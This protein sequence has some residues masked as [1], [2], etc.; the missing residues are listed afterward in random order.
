M[1]DKVRNSSRQTAVTTCPG[2]DPEIV[3]SL[4][5]SVAA[6]AWTLSLHRHDDADTVLLDSGG[7]ALSP[8]LGARLIAHATALDAATIA[9]TFDRQPQ[10]D[11]IDNGF[12][13]GGAAYANSVAR[14]T[15]VFAFAT[16]EL[17]SSVDRSVKSGLRAARR[18]VAPYFRLWQAGMASAARSDSLEA[19]LNTVDLGIILVD[20]EGRLVFVNELASDLLERSTVL[21]RR[22][23]VLAAMTLAETIELQSSIALA[24]A[25][26]ADETV[27]RVLPERSALLK[28][29]NGSERVI[30]ATLPARDPADCAA[31]VAAVILVLA[32]SDDGEMLVAPACRLYGLSAVET[33]L[34]CHIVAG[35]SLQEASAAMRIKEQT[36]RT[37]LKQVFAKTDVRRQ[38]DL[39]RLLL[40][41]LI[42]TRSRVGLFAA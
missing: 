29:E 42:R 10:A 17:G 32:P 35:R 4:V 38:V 18:L 33:R 37:Y 26:N 34:A 8:T 6:S 3:S 12:A 7:A 40:G 9:D 28:L 25:M 30:V 5:T 19:A 31:A 24:I 1:L 39:V 11:D 16:A 20:R 21:R 41:T 2:I 14:G 36:A 23:Q 13:L 27:V 15:I 22:G